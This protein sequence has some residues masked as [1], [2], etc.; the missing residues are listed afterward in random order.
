[1]KGRV[2]RRLGDFAGLAHFA[3]GEVPPSGLPWPLLLEA[4]P[5]RPRVESYIARSTVLGLYGH[6]RVLAVAALLQLDRGTVELMNIAVEPALRGRGLGRRLMQCAAARAEMAGA[7]EM[8]VGT[9]NSSLGELAFYQKMGFR[10]V[11]VDRDYFVREYPQAIVENGIA[12]RDRIRLALIRP[13][14]GD[15]RAL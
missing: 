12:C 9:G 3:L 14:R 1:M 11:G 13:A 15:P 5:Y 4:D 8:V 10:I 7:R 2:K 6:D